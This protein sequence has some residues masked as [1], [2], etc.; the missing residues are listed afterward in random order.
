MKQRPWG[1]WLV[2]GWVDFQPGSCRSTW[3]NQPKSRWHILNWKWPRNKMSGSP[4]R[5][6]PV[7]SWDCSS[8]LS[9]VS[10]LPLLIPQAPGFAYFTVLYNHPTAT[11]L[12]VNRLQNSGFRQAQSHT[13]SSVFWK[14]ACRHY[15][16]RG[17][18]QKQDEKRYE[19]TQ[20]LR[21]KT[22]LSLTSFSLL[23][24]LVKV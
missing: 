11:L 23:Q 17:E 18:A 1:Y 20:T 3:Q 7:N 10:Y 13:A 9:W 15:W 24:H 16:D 8:V 14:H 19:E 2:E 6:S 21:N 5:L 4:K 12:Y 22:D